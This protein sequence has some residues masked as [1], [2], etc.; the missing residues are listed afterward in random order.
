MMLLSL[1][2]YQV[3]EYME[4]LVAPTFQYDLQ[5]VRDIVM[6]MNTP[7]MR[8]IN[9][10]LIDKTSSQEILDLEK[11]LTNFGNYITSHEKVVTAPTTVQIQLRSSITKFLLAHV[12]QIEDNYLL[13]SC[14]ESQRHEGS[15][16]TPQKPYFEWVHGT[17]AEYTSCP[18]AFIFF[19]CLV[20]K[21]S[22]TDHAVD[23]DIAGIGVGHIDAEGGS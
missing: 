16:I 12:I 5:P 1:L 10:S 6:G 20:D 3:D 7:S 13:S 21:S 8:P 11:V 18:F 9:G 23:P 14:R 4:A 2:V 19:S 17:S 15:P 22:E